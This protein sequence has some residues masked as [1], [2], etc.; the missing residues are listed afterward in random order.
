[1]HLNP[2]LTGLFGDM[3]ALGYCI[4]L[5]SQF[6]GWKLVLCRQVLFQGGEGK[7]RPAVKLSKAARLA[8][9][10]GALPKV[11]GTVSSFPPTALPAIE[12]LRNAFDRQILGDG[13][14][15]HRPSSMRLQDARR[16]NHGH[17]KS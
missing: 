5:K 7:L 14:F 17:G 4:T 11:R 8:Q 9:L 13:C 12:L 6:Q 16:I 3:T 15:C 2:L 1:M 10:D